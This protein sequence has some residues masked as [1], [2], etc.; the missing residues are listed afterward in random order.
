MQ[1]HDKIVALAAIKR[2]PEKKKKME[3]ITIK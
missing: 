1:Q 2:K 3:E